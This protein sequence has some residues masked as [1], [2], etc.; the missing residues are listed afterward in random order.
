MELL[1]GVTLAEARRLLEAKWRG[2]PA[3]AE[4]VKIEQALGRRLARAIVSPEDVPAF[5][6]STVDGLA[7]R[8][9]DT[10][11]AS[12]G[13]P[14]Y[15]DLAGEVRIGEVAS[16][17]EAAGKAVR[18]S[19][20]A[21]LP[22]GT[23][24]VVMVEYTEPLDEKTV[25]IVRP[26]GPGENVIQTGED[27]R[28]GAEVLA[29]GHLLRPA[30]LGFLSA[31]GISEV[32][33]AAACRV[34]IISTGDELVPVDREL[35]LGRIRDSNSYTLLGLVQEAGGEPALYGIVADDFEAQKKLIKT[36]VEREDL[37]LIS[38]GS[39][40]GARDMTYL[41][42]DALNPGGIMFH[43]VAI[44]P[45]KPTLGAD[46]GGRMVIGLPG[47]PASAVIA[48]HVLIRPLLTP[49]QKTLVP[50]RLNR[51]IASAPGRDDFVRVRL[52]REGGE[53]V[54]EPLLGKSGLLNTLVG[55]DGLVHVP[56]AKQGY[57][58][59][60]NIEVELL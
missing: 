23:D 45:G 9:R 46:V 16:P 24:S 51:N 22:P 25:G 29:A 17:L 37:V 13:I 39:S 44:K 20:G 60:E 21:M 7:V 48:F 34:G 8:A 31:L 30:D 2:R 59:G 11:G 56:A 32:E 33:V 18:I 52:D 36:A 5:P 4:L 42:L 10:F 54:A 55:A 26:V 15:L 41:V 35:P 57:R 1:H 38:G 53:W 14:A 49:G 40:A 47:H 58:A 12:E 19:T 50:A 3:R 43:G 6:R 28:Q 27:I